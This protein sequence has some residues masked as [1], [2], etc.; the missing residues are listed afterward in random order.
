MIDN[1]L[2]RE[3]TIPDFLNYLYI[4]GLKRV[5]PEAVNIIR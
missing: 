2:T 5:K 4:D 3:R 1:N